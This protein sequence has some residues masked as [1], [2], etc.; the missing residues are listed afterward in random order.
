MP[1]K[2]PVGPDKVAQYRLSELFKECQFDLPAGH[3]HLIR[4]DTSRAETER[5]PSANV[6]AAPA[7]KAPVQGD[8]LAVADRMCKTAKHTDVN[9][10]VWSDR[11]HHP[12]IFRVS[13][14]AT[15]I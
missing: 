3:R 13:Y 10:C 2:L 6:V 5:V 9:K 12:V 11:H 15:V 4:R 1:C 14:D 7:K 8:G